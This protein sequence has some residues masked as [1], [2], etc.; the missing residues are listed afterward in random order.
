M[1]PTPMMPHT[2]RGGT[3]ELVQVDYVAG[4]KDTF[5][6]TVSTSMNFSLNNANVVPEDEDA[7]N[8]VLMFQISMFTN[9]QGT[10]VAPTMTVDGTPMSV[11]WGKWVGIS[12]DQ[13]IAV[14]MIRIPPEGFDTGLVNVSWPTLVAAGST[15]RASANVMFNVNDDSL[16]FGSGFVVDTAGD[17]EAGPLNVPALGAVWAVS[18]QNNGG[19]VSAL[20][21]SVSDSVSYTMQ[22]PQVNTGSPRYMTGYR[23]FPTG[24]SAELIFPNGVPFRPVIAAVLK[25]APA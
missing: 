11:K 23:L 12:A 16:A 5:S 20:I 4:S 19:D 6:P 25:G 8:S 1:I 3:E 2:Y 10:V 9:T 18:L 7:P 21:R 17:S 15:V 14:G 24:D 22:S 13:H